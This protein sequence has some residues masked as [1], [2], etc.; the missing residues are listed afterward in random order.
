MGDSA[1]RIRALEWIRRN[2]DI[3]ARFKR[4]ALNEAAHE[5]RVSVQWLLEDVRKFDR[6][7]NAGDVVKVNN[8][9]APIF[10]RELVR[11]CPEIRPYIELRRSIYD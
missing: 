6:V 1:T 11:Q 2:P 3:W 10:A 4:H 5:R 9:F 7:D 8:S